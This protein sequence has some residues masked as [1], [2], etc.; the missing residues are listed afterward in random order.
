MENDERITIKQMMPIPEGYEVM[1]E[2]IQRDGTEEMEAARDS[3]F[4]YCL[5][6]VSDS[7]G[8][9]IA[10]YNLAPGGGIEEQ[11]ESLMVPTRYCGKC[12]SPSL[13]S[14]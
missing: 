8:D 6:L 9:R 14:L 11:A 10:L 1:M 13:Q 12:G 5:A 2:V 4:P 7:S 3:L